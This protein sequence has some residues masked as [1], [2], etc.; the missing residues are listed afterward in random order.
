MGIPTTQALGRGLMERFWFLGVQEFR[1]E[2]PGV[3]GLRGRG[4]RGLL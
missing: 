4:F 1:A 2:G 3:R